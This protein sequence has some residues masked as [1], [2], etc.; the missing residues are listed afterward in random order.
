MEIH[1]LRFPGPARYLGSAPDGSYWVQWFAG[2]DFGAIHWVFRNGLGTG[3]WDASEDPLPHLARL[4]STGSVLEER[5]S[6]A[7]YTRV[8][9]S[10][11]LVW[12][13]AWATRRSAYG[14]PMVRGHDIATDECIWQYARGLVG[15]VG[16]H[17]AV[18]RLASGLDLFDIRTG[19]QLWTVQNSAQHCAWDAQRVFVTTGRQ[20][21]ALSR[22]TGDLVWTHDLDAV[23]DEAPMV[24]F[25]P[26]LAPPRGP[27][28]VPV[29]H[30]GGRDFRT[31]GVA[32]EV[33]G[34]T[35]ER[36]RA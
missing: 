17:W 3:A 1:A 9:G 32:F 23:C 15:V 14:D 19:S 24:R 8:H 12:C 10:T 11:G 16:E 22:K 34:A 27:L 21:K 20:V 26:T 33:D 36:R 30:V 35:R 13:G 25:S 18:G 5:Q 4:S 28:E 6:T 29:I 7:F 2:G 31:Q